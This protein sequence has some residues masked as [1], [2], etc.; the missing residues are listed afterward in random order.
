MLLPNSATDLSAA[1]KLSD[2][3]LA[4]CGQEPNPV[5]QCEFS[6]ALAQYRLGDYRAAV[7]WAGKSL[8]HKP[9]AYDSWNPSRE[10]EAHALEAMAYYR[11]NELED[12]LS[13]LKRTSEFVRRDSPRRLGIRDTLLADWLTCDILMDEAKALI[14]SQS[15]PA[16][17][18]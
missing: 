12:A 17:P 15:T 7:A 6:K 14:E 13:S 2:V 10:I 18:K 16:L 8:A 5:A 11:L 9:T 1:D 3:A 4:N